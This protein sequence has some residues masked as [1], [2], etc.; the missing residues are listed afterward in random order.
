MFTTESVTQPFTGA[1]RHLRAGYSEGVC[2]DAGPPRR[3]AR[4][5]SAPL[6][7]A[8]SACSG[9]RQVPSAWDTARS[10]RSGVGLTSYVLR[11]MRRGRGEGHVCGVGHGLLSE[12]K[13]EEP[14]GR[15]Q[16]SRQ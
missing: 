15:G 1:P 3:V 4:S 11:A 16:S 12:S 14:S 5:G 2:A 8:A 9:V 7:G 13:G 10:R 6:A